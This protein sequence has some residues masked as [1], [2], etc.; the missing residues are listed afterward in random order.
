MFVPF[1]ANPQQKWSI[2][3]KLTDNLNPKVTCIAGDFLFYLKIFISEIAY[4]NAF[5]LIYYSV[6][7]LG[8][9]N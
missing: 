1:A 8:R 3:A 6:K 9:R 7:Y 4:M 2:G 5:L